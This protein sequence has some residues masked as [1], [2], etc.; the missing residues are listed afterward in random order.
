MWSS[1]TLVI[2]ATPPSHALLASSRPPSPTSTTQTSTPARANH[3]KRGAGQRLE[4]GGRPVAAL[5]PV[6]GLKDLR[7]DRPEVRRRD[8]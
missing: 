1:D 8:G 4:L 3:S 6:R 5:D 2:A 7:D